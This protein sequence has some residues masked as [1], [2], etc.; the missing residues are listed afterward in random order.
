MWRST[1]VF[2]LVVCFGTDLFS[3]VYDDVTRYEFS[4]KFLTQFRVC[5]ISIVGFSDDSSACRILQCSHLVGI[6]PYW[7]TLV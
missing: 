7:L 3:V 6:N 1:R 2:I 5:G 4:S